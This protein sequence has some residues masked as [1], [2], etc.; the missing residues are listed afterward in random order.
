MQRQNPPS[1]V[2]PTTGDG[3]KELET[4]IQCE[5]GGRVWAFQLIAQN[6]GW[7]LRGQARSYF[8]KQL[9]QQAVMEATALPIIANDIEVV[10]IDLEGGSRLNE[11]Q[12]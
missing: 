5:L 11:E 4:R 10:G 1:A 3:V 6:Q 7:V 9:A 8:A 2:D 12:L